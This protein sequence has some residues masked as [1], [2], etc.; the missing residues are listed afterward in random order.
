MLLAKKLNACHCTIT[1]RWKRSNVIKHVSNL[2]WKF[3]ERNALIPIENSLHALNLEAIK[4]KCSN[5]SWKTKYHC[6][7]GNNWFRAKCSAQWFNWGR[8]FQFH[9][10]LT[11]INAIIFERNKH[12]FLKQKTF[13][14]FR[15]KWKRVNL[16]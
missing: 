6:F 5:R 12:S 2:I 7:H 11:K 8:L 14:A 9:K 4:F 1:D 13:K 3:H 15:F 10:M 16:Y